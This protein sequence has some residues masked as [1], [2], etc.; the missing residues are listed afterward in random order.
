MRASRLPTLFVA[1][2]F[3]LLPSTALSLPHG[4]ANSPQ[5]LSGTVVDASGLAVP[6]AVVSLHSTAG[7]RQTI[8]DLAG[9]FVFDSLPAGDASIGVTLEGFAPAT[10]QVT[11]STTNLRV[12]LQPVGVSEE[13]TVHGSALIVSEHDHG[14]EDADA[15]ARRPAGCHRRDQGR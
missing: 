5:T 4:Q 11:G 13:V 7:D 3:G 8:T 6:G 1:L 9:R 14:H 12:V 2:L 15:A 10:I